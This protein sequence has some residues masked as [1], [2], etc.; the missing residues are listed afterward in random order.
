MKIVVTPMCEKIV[1]WA[2][3][4]DYTVNKFPDT[5][6]N[7]DIAI[8]LAERETNMDSI[9]ISLNTFKQIKESI[10]KISQIFKTDIDEETIEKIFKN[11]RDAYN[12]INN[13]DNIRYENKDINVKV[14]SNF[15]KDIVCDLGFNIINDENTD[16]NIV[17]YPDYL[18][19]QISMENKDCKL[20][21]VASHSNVPNNPLERAVTRYNII[22]NNI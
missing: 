11:N 1:L 7:M 9:N 19:N 14:Y 21:K 17:I 4:C 15:L 6:K 10:N 13:L 5:E 16:Y 8:V 2:G 22:L 18:S 20:I 12:I 3:I